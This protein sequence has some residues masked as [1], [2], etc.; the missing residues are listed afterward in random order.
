MRNRK[1]EK[2][3]SNDFNNLCQKNARQKGKQ[4]QPDSYTFVLHV[5]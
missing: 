3:L 4:K 2:G 1:A 5:I